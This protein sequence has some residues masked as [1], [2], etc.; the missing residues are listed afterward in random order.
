VSLG[1]VSVGARLAT[2][3]F[4]TCRAVRVYSNMSAVMPKKP[5]LS[6]PVPC[7]LVMRMPLDPEN[8]PAD[9]RVRKVLGK[10]DSLFE[11]LAVE[12]VG[13]D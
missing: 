2:P 13:D 3:A 5:P 12:G 7:V 6:P 9:S 11:L 8:T 1:H 10:W 4:I